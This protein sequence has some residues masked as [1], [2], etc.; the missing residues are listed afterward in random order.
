MFICTPRFWLAS[1]MTDADIFL[2]HVEVHGDDRLA[3][4]GGLA[5]VRHLGRVLHHDDLAIALTTW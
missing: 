3:D 4:L 5:L 1:V 2:R